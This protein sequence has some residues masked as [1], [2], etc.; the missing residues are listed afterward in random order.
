MHFT[1]FA[2]LQ[3]GRKSMIVAVRYDRFHS[4]WWYARLF[5]IFIWFHPVREYQTCLIFSAN[6]L[7]TFVMHLI[8]TRCIFLPEFV[9]FKM[10]WTTCAHHTINNWMLNLSP[11]TAQNLQI[12]SDFGQ[13]ALTILC[14]ILQ[15]FDERIW[16]QNPHKIHFYEKKMNGSNINNS[17]SFSSFILTWQ[18][19]IKQVLILRTAFKLH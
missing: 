16:R 4:V 10:T 15:H 2:N 3:F 9:V 12:G 14:N 18:D 11:L 5:F 7:N 8:A 17:D 6:F 1:T 13:L 19:S